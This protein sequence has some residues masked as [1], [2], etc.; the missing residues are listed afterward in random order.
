MT[1]AFATGA[2]A[3]FGLVES[4]NG[5]VIRKHI[6]YGYIAA[7]HAAAIMAV[8]RAHFNPYLNFHRPCGVPETTMDKKGKQRRLYRRYATPWELLQQI[9]EFAACLKPDIT[10]Q[11]LELCANARSDTK[12]ARLMQEAKRKLLAGL[13]QNRSA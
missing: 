2:S 13:R 5:A 9:P 7:V 11:G 10:K 3:G 4:K 8:Y 6:G 12:A 1:S